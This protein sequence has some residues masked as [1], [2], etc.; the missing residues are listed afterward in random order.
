MTDHMSQN[1]LT[2]SFNKLV[3]VMKRCFQH[4]QLKG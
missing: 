3:E 4:I 1:S 2:E